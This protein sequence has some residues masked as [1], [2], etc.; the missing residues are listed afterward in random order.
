MKK[1]LILFSALALLA[2][3][4]AGGQDDNG[5]VVNGQGGRVIVEG[6]GG[7]AGLSAPQQTSTVGQT[8]QPDQQ[9]SQ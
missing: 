6:I 3:G 1:L 8:G 2:A 9:L 5:I 7:T 4:C